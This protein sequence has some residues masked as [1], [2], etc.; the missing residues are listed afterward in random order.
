MF[1]SAAV[2]EK[3][4]ECTYLTAVVIVAA[5]KHIPVYHQNADYIFW[6][7]GTI[8]FIYSYFKNSFTQ[9]SRDLGAPVAQRIKRWSTNRAVPGSNPT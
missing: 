3:H 6:S 5:V 9:A 2:R 8:E 1:I 7:L 4:S